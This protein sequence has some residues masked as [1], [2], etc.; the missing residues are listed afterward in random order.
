MRGGNGNRRF[1]LIFVMLV[2]AAG[3]AAAVALALT[4]IGEPNNELRPSGQNAGRTG[5]LERRMT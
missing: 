5:T 2:W 3:V 4:L 1:W